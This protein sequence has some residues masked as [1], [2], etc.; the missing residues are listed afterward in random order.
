LT[1]GYV[2]GILFYY[3]TGH[4]IILALAHGYEHPSWGVVA[5]PYRSIGCGRPKQGLGE[6]LL[7]CMGRRVPVA[8]RERI[9]GVLRPGDAFTRLPSLL[10]EIISD[11][12]ETLGA[13]WAGL[14]GSWAAGCGDRDSDVD[15]LVSYGDELVGALRDMKSA[16]LISQC[17]KHLV[18]RKRRGRPDIGVD[19]EYIEESILDSCYRGIPYTLRPLTRL[20]QADCA[21]QRVPLGR[22]MVRAELAAGER[23]RVPSR[24]PLHVLGSNR[25]L[26]GRAI[27]LES[28]RT[29]YQ[30]LT[31]GLYTIIGDLYY[32]DNLLLLTPD[33]G[34]MVIRERPV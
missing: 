26:P 28:W 29:R 27:I 34:G 14:T 9:L 25:R 2:D 6:I 3:N 5:S 22:V 19:D 24:Y 30:E 23:F 7:P 11:F 1:I 18:K 31:P 33:H 20:V 13:G 17:K 12:V 16:G 15:I 10:R 4:S 32:E 8:R 21:K